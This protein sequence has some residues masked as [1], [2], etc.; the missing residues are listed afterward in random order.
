MRETMLTVMQRR[1]VPITARSG[2]RE[3]PAV[4]VSVTL[5]SLMFSHCSEGGDS[6]SGDACLPLQRNFIKVVYSG[7]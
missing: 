1:E 4:N 7:I 3:Y 6:A 2:S 5:V